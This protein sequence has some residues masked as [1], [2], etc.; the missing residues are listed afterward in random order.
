MSPNLATTIPGLVAAIILMVKLFVP[1]ALGPVLDKAG[2]FVV[3][4][5]VFLLG[6]FSNRTDE[7]MPR[8][9]RRK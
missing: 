4:L 5:S 9:L 2:D 8:M 7:Q 1:E 6:Y 3:A